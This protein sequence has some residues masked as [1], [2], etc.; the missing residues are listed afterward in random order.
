MYL[1][2][3]K[4]SQQL[5]LH[6]YKMN[7]LRK[8]LENKE[9]REI[10]KPY[11]KPRIFY[12]LQSNK[13]FTRLQMDLMD[14]AGTNNTYPTQMNR[15][16]RYVMCVIDVFTRKAFVRPLKTKNDTD[17]LENFEKIIKQIQ[18]EAKKSGKN[19]YDNIVIDSDN[20]SSFKSRNFRKFCKENN[21]IQVFVKPSDTRG[22]GV[23]ERFNLT[24]RRMMLVYTTYKESKN[25]IDI[26]D[27]LVDLYNNK[28]HSTIQMTPNEATEEKNK[29]AIR[30][31]LTQ[32][33]EQ[34]ERKVGDIPLGTKVR[35][36]NNKTLVDKK[37]T[38]N[39]SP[40]TYVVESREGNN[41]EVDGKR[42]TYK[43]DELQISTA[44]PVRRIQVDSRNAQNK[45]QRYTEQAKLNRKLNQ[46]GVD[47][48]N[49]VRQ[50][51]AVKRREIFD[52]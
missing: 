2:K 9:V 34:A 20:E 21:I 44:K 7:A 39:W 15:G 30:E 13:A 41:Y 52:L 19:E 37:T 5:S 31:I 26:L 40:E 43:K 49:I 3:I 8:I 45:A 51:R 28:E 50:K 48:E 10:V 35:I 38:Q 33:T 32:R 42:T 11:V 6:I 29:E 12:P 17:V 18:K 47:T 16:F 22:K 4:N 24:L 14:M 36:L 23:V 25:W 27:S 1:S 46:A